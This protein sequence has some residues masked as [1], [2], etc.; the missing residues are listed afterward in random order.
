M[1]LA[2]DRLRAE[3]LL[4]DSLIKLYERWRWLSQHSD[5]DA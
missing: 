3:E 4:Q 5:L 1:L 2:D